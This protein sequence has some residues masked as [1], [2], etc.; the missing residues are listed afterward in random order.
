MVPLL[1][2]TNNVALCHG[3]TGVSDTA[4]I[5]LWVVDYTLQAST[6]GIREAFF[7]QGVGYRYNFVRPLSYSSY[8][9]PSTV[10]ARALIAPSQIQPVSLN[11]SILDNSPLDPPVPPH[12]Q[13]AYYAALVVNTLIG[14]T[15][16]SQIIELAVDDSDVSGYAAFEAGVLVRAMFVNLHPWLTTSTGARPSVHI[17][18]VFSGGS[19][20]GS[21]SV[22]RLVIGHADDTANVTWAGQSFET[23]SGAPSGSVVKE[24]VTLSEGLD[25]PATHAVLIDF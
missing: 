11:R 18:F 23:S 15:G 3:A 25:L 17:D 6:L 12:V 8:S 10:Y 19:K 5:A 1:S 16:A 14:S 22:R 13:P 9:S 4:G 24:T 21:A 2:E 20:T 7:H